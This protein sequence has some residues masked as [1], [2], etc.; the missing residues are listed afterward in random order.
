MRLNGCAAE[1][2]D[3][4]SRTYLEATSYMHELEKMRLLAVSVGEARGENLHY[5]YNGR[6]AFQVI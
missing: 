2:I 4:G 6:E 3:P 1:L 5:L